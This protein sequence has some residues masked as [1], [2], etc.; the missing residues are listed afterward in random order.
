MIIHFY[1]DIKIQKQLNNQLLVNE[2]FIN[3]NKHLRKLIH[4]YLIIIYS[5]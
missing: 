1:H 2:Y 3:F 5:I 4:G